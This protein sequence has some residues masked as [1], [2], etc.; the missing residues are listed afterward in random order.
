MFYE[1]LEGRIC[2]QS[3]GWE[4]VVAVEFRCEMEL[5]RKLATCSVFASSGWRCLLTL[6]PLFLVDVGPHFALTHNRHP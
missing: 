6:G 5:L 2:R 3:V 4:M 1:I